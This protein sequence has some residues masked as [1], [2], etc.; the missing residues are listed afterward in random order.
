[1]IRK[2]VTLAFFLLVATQPLA[3][4]TYVSARST[5]DWPVLSFQEVVADL[6][7]PVFLTNAKDGS[8]RLFVVE[9][10]GQIR[11]VD[12][13]LVNTPYLDIHDRVRSPR[14]GGGSEE[15]LLSVAFPPGFNSTVNHFYIYY[16]NKAGDNQVSRFTQT[17]D[18]NLADPNSEEV[19]LYLSHPQNENHNGGLLLFG[20]DGYL[21][22]GTGDGGGGGDPFGN[23]QNPASL[24]GKILR[25]DVEF[26]TNPGFTP[27]HYVYLPLAPVESG[28]TPA[29]KYRIPESNPYVGVPGFRGEIWALGLRNPWRFSFDSLNKDLYIGDVGQNLWEEVDYQPANST[30]GENYGWNIMEGKHCYGSSS[31]DMTGLVL[32]FYEYSHANACSVTGGYVYRG[33]DYPGMQGIYFFGDWCSGRIWGAQNIANIWQVEELNPIGP[34][35]SSFGEDESG[36]I[37]LV[38]YAANNGK[39]FRLQQVIP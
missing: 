22:I 4:G 32:P 3:D 21:Y 29:A 7:Y 11:I 24:L 23:A 6:D 13:G 30:G 33:Q 34:H 25:I 9:Q 20:P 19:I 38:V 36:E 15:G 17:A 39:V 2:F 1:M 8:G 16:T 14:S 27:S 5:A 28:S 35:L 37:Y 10:P 12:N 26:T 31:C 18:P